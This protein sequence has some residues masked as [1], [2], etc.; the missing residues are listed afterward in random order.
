MKGKT[1]A[2]LAATAFLLV[3]GMFVVGQHIMGKEFQ[4]RRG[5]GIAALRA[6]NLT[7][8]Q[9]AKVKDIFESNRSAVQ[10]IREA[11]K[12]NHDKLAA[13]NGS[14]DEAQVSAIAKD[15]GNLMAQMIVARERVKSQI[16]ALL[17]D[18]QRAKAAQLR[19]SMKQRFQERIKSLGE[20]TDSLQ[21]A[22][23]EE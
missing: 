3:G 16:L 10:P 9:K 21:G 11:L 22:G 6:L 2:I 4:A 19:D 20:K 12:A 17:T 23:D 7:D 15:Q 5:P 1:I 13:M 18:D 8:D 14:F